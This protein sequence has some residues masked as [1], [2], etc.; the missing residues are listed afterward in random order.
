MT[1][2]VRALAVCALAA[3]AVHVLARA[4][5]RRLQANPDPYTISALSRDPEGEEMFLERPDGTR[6]KAVVHEGDGPTVVFVHA[7]WAALFEWNVIWARL[8]AA[9]YRLIAYDHRGHGQSTIGSE[10]LGAA[11]MGR[12]LQA[13]LDHFD[14]RN[15]VL[16]GHSMGGF[17]A[18]TYILANPA[19]AAARVRH[20]VLLASFAGDVLRGAPQ[21]RLQVSLVRTGI[22]QRMVQSSTYGPLLVASFYGTQPSPSAMEAHRQM[23]ARQSLKL[24]IPVLKALIA[25]NYYPRL[26]EIKVPSTVVCGTQDRTSPPVHAH[27]LHEGI[28]GARL[29]RIQDAGHVLNWE[30]PE[31]VADL[32]KSVAATAPADQ[33]LSS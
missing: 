18:L 30:A 9:G 22:L 3:A 21:N 16:V 19:E 17:V 12:D 1:L 33:A 11:Q 20:N 25:E 23:L 4:T 26:S 10:G 8:R 14:V 24:M 27:D 28:P 15:G 31:A 32:I 5:V 2:L 6:L 13:V 7:L 29:L